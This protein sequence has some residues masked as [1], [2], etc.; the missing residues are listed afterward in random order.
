[1]RGTSPTGEL[2]RLAW[3]IYVA[4]IALMANG[5]IDTVMAGRLSVADLAAVGVASSIQVT[6]LMSL[7]AVLLAL[8]PMVAH[9]YGAGRHEEVGREIH[10]SVWVSLALAVILIL[11]L[12]HPDPLLAISDL[13]PEVEAKVRAYLDASAWGVPAAIALRIYFGLFTGIGRPRSVMHLNLAALALKLPLNAVLMYGLFGAPALGAA[14]CAVAT[15]VDYWLIALVAWGWCLS[16]PRYASLGLGAPIAPPDRAAIVAFLKL[17][18]PIGLTFV[19]DVTAFTFMA[20]FIARLGPVSSAA[21]QIA[22]NLSV[23][24][25]MLPLSI[26]NA[27]TIL[28]GQALGAGEP[29]RAR[30]ICWRALGLGVAFGIAVSVAFWLAAGRIAQLYTT[31]AKVQAMAVPLIGLVGYYHLAD[32][33]QAVAVNALRGYQ[34]SFIPMLIYTTCLWGVGLG[35]G[36]LLGLTDWLGPARGASGFWLAGI[37]GLGLV[38]VLVTLYL[39]QVSRVRL[40]DGPAS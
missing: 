24:A 1:M 34:R 29:R 22:A 7:M 36:V 2:V 3:P 16:N 10:Q 23:F 21:H 31:D 35:G 15:T 25:F 18:V 8:P 33:L 37:A 6:L 13:Q 32:A 28:A 9:L 4:Q 39:E 17:G 12:R 20:L 26:G 11:L 27:A 14:G 40:G 38:A 30:Q 19:A 5:V